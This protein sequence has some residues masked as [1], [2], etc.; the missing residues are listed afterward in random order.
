MF[1]MRYGIFKESFFLQINRGI[2]TPSWPQKERN[3]HP[4]LANYNEKENE[5]I[6]NIK[7]INDNNL[8]V[9]GQLQTCWAWLS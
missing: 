5:I 9:V 6:E 1:F 4:T 7:N 8:T 3:M 2:L